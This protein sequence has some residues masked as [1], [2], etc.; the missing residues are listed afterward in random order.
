MILTTLGYNICLTVYNEQTMIVWRYEELYKEEIDHCSTS[1]QMFQAEQRCN[2]W[3]QLLR[4]ETGSVVPRQCRDQF[5]LRPYPRQQSR[6][7]LT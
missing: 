1:D 5:Y 2:E 6:G 7:L 3:G 4:P